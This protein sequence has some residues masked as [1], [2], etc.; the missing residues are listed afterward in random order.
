MSQTARTTIYL[1]PLLLQALKRKGLETNKSVSALTNE[2]LRQ[3]LQEDYD[4]LA[5]FQE[6]EKEDHMSFES[7][8]TSLKADGK[9]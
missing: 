8:L 1:D 9:L 2:A 5:S 6:R 7:F 4:D 3:Q